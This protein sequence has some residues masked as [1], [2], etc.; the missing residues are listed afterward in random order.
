[1]NNHTSFQEVRLRSLSK[2]FG[3]D[4]APAEQLFGKDLDN[5]ITEA[6]DRLFQAGL[7]DLKEMQ[8]EREAGYRNSV[9][10]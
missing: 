10:G 3:V 5:F 8:K 9:N 7:E 6:E 2:D 4:I 1:M